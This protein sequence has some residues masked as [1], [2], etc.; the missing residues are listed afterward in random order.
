MFDIDIEKTFN[1]ISERWHS[2]FLFWFYATKV[3]KIHKHKIGF[4]LA[5]YTENKKQYKKNN[6]IET[7]QEYIYKGSIRN[8]FELIV[9]PEYYSQKN[10][11]QETASIFLNK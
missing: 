9:Y 3:P 5:I 7:L 6:F 1:W 8:H 11:N 10:K 2:I 4:L